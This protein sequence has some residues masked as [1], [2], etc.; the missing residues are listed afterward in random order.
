MVE[1]KEVVKYERW[2]E[3]AN[4]FKAFSDENRIQILSLLQTGEKCACTLL[5]NLHIRQSTLSHHMKILC[6]ANIV[7][8]RKEGKWTY[9]SIDQNGTAKA[10]DLLAQVTTVYS[11]AHA[12][13]CKEI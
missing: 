8:P 7:V 3:N 4:I 10:K 9:Y 5:E 1:Q 12:C 11:D 6:E 13:S 2:K